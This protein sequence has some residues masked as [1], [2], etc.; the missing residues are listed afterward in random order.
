M[1]INAVLCRILS[2]SKIRRRVRS[3][4]PHLRDRIFLVY[5]LATACLGR[6]QDLRLCRLNGL[7]TWG[8]RRVQPTNHHIEQL[9]CFTPSQNSVAVAF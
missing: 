2:S 4:T 3:H 5:P 6:V 8:F 1:T 9:Y 7:D